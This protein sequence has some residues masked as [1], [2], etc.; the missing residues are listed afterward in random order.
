MM[1][2]ERSANSQAFVAY[3]SKDDVL[4]RMIS[5]GVA[6]ANRKL[7]GHRYEPWEFNDVAGNP[8]ISPII[9]G[10]EESKF[11]VADIT[12]LNL[13]VVYEIGYSIGRGRRCFLVRHGPTEGDSR[14][15]REAGIFDTLGYES[16]NDDDGLANTLT[17][18]IDPAPLLFTVSLDRRA[19]VYVVEPP[20][21]GGIATLMTSRLKKARYKYRS[22]NPTED[23]RLSAVDAIRLNRPVF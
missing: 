23:A 5:L 16:Y 13:N 11:V 9:E 3:S 15:A 1:Q 19:P 22:F 18:Y 8:L 14:I 2:T 20:A 4:A 21:K 6:K 12:Y 10:I 17:A 7:S